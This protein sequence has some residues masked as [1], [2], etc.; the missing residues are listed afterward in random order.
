M[1]KKKT[2][3]RIFAVITAFMMLLSN[4]TVIAAEKPEQAASP[5]WQD[6]FDLMDYVGENFYDKKPAEWLEVDDVSSELPYYPQGTLIA[7]TNKEQA[8]A[9]FVENDG[10]FAEKNHGD[11]E[12]SLDGDAASNY[13]DF[14]AAGIALVNC[15][16]TATG[17]KYID[18]IA[19]T[20]D[21]FWT[22][23]N[24]PFYAKV[25]AD[26][27][28]I[29]SSEDEAPD[30]ASMEQG[31]YWILQSDFDTYDNAIETA[32]TTTQGW[33]DSNLWTAHNG[34]PDI[35]RADMLKV[36]N[37]VTSAYNT[38]LEKLHEGTKSSKEPVSNLAAADT[39]S[40][41]SGKGSQTE[42]PQTPVIVNEVTFSNGFKSQSTLEGV[43]G[44]TFVAGAIYNDD[45]TQI[46]QAVGLTEEEIKS[47]V[48]V[49]YYIC[50]SLNK[51]MN[52]KLSQA[53]SAQGY[54][55]LG[56]MKNDLY[57]L[58]K[59]DIR[60]IKTTSET[61]TVILGVP[62]HLKSDQYEF[63]IF[64]YDENGNLTTL[65]D[66]DTDKSTITVQ[67]KSFGY[68]AIGYQIKK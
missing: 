57:R 67:A 25:E 31:T 12:T 53:V 54:R 58:N 63:V 56:V 20:L 62:S 46:K 19:S 8:Y 34:M 11:A 5:T 65:K 66:T 61:L 44:N 3:F 48:V 40:A 55:L 6:V 16:K 1:K 32:L 47:G 14:Y 45:Q 64:C 36:I 23:N 7:S 42:E 29:V 39:S 24:D 27:I 10:S 51:A 37:D 59:G 43:Y 18:D 60:L 15:L 30:T 21:N 52:E 35:P 68:W 22:K 28:I 4:I 9:A 38:L 49:K 2:V 33:E 50:N 17:T 41:S 13:A 26:Q